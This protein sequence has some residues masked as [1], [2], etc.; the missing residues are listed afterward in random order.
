MRKPTSVETLNTLGR[1]QL[2]PH[3]FMRDMLYSEIANFHGLQNIPDYPDLAIKAGRKLCNEILEPLRATFGHV[4][5]RSAYRS[6][7]IN[8]FGN[9]KMKTGKKGYNCALDN[10]ARHTWDYLDKNNLMGATACIVIPWF[11]ERH[12]RGVPWYALA[13]WIHDHRHHITYSELYFFPTYS[14]FNIRWYAGRPEHKIES[15]M[16]PRTLTKR[17][18][19]NHSGDH[20]SEYPEFPELILS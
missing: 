14:A 5:I 10:D 12:K 6:R 1:V 19:E 20:S 3:F 4:S 18:Y 13:W 16:Q 2:S 9:D 11:M 8:K 17:G 15:Y 7:L